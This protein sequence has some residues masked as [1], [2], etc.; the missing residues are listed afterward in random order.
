MIVVFLYFS[1]GKT[2]AVRY[3]KKK[4]FSLSKNIRIE[5]KAV[6]YAKFYNFQIR[7]ITS[8]LPKYLTLFL[9]LYRELDHQNLCKFVGCCTDAANFC[10][11]MEYCPKGSISDVLLNDDIPLNWAF[12]Y[13]G[14]FL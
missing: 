14:N 7:Y 3:V 4:E 1:D 6:R 12:R 11:L 2:V 8:F 13:C 9:M 5:V 10:V